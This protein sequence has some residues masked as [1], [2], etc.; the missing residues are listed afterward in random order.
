MKSWNNPILAHE[1]NESEHMITRDITL[2]T[3]RGKTPI[4]FTTSKS[5]VETQEN[6][7]VVSIRNHYFFSLTNQKQIRSNRLI[8][9]HQP[10]FNNGDEQQIVD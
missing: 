1:T 2:H 10:T 8:K 5:M 7:F 3:N 4:S 9:N 6:T